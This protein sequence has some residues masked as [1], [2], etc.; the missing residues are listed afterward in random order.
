MHAHVLA[1]FAEKPH[2]SFPFICL[3]VSGGH[4]QIIHVEAP[5][6]MEILGQTIDDAAGEAFDKTGKML[7]IALSRRSTH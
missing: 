3:T 5:L 4:T 2:P 7:G 1:H 6:K